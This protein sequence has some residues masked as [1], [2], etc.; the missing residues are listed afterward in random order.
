MLLFGAKRSGVTC[1]D[2]YFGVE[3]GGDGSIASALGKIE[4]RHN[5]F[6][7]HL[8]LSMVCELVWY[9]TLDDSAHSC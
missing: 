3:V 7:L 4:K 6:G 5:P 8:F 9:F 1:E 2:L